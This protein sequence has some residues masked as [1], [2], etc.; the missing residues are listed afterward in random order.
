MTKAENLSKGKLFLLLAALFLS[1]MCTM[2]DLVVNPIVSNL[3]HAFADAPEWLINLGVTGP[4]L[5]GLPFGLMAGFLCDR[6]DK[7]W[8]MVAG[9]AIFTASAVFGAAF[10]NVYYFVAMRLFATGVGWGITNTAALAILA[11]LFTDETEH[12]KYVGW[13][14]S[15]MS[16]MGA[17]MA[18]VA[19]VL[20]V[21]AWQNAFYTYVIAIPV[22]IMLVAFLPKFPAAHDT[23]ANGNPSPKTTEAPKGWW[24]RLIPLSVQ[25][26]F[27]A[28]CYFVLLYMISLYVVD[29][30]VGDE[31]FTGMLSS[32]STIATAISSLAFGMVYKKMKNA[33]YLPALFVL[34]LCFLAMAF[35]PSPLVTIASVAV[36][37]LMW[38][39]YFC[40]F[41][42]R[43]TELAPA[44]KAGTAT[45]IVAF[46]DGLAAAGCSYLL[47]G[48]IGATGG[49]S[50]T[51]WPVF[52]II[53]IVVGLVSCLWF[54]AT[55]K[56]V[57]GEMA[58]D[59]LAA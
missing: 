42:T 27:V 55:R 1:S 51:V 28:I 50:V 39:F 31:A 23:G 41:Y 19:G 59:A 36:A 20:A 46:S 16:V 9:F 38:P 2:G 26:F 56:K 21:A 35:F 33:V 3:Y 17:L 14:N 45:S 24:T 5:V 6:I 29:A 18:A 54:L 58:E 25:I 48:L 7:K 32:V 10:D 44:S 53:L 15:A 37:G 13:Y 8:V 47:T 4:A 11:E 49:T 52:G 40:Y 30:G 12:G 34:G 57:R 22:L 43:C